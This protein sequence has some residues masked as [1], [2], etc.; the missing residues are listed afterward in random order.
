MSEDETPSSV[1]QTQPSGDPT[2]DAGRSMLTGDTAPA[3]PGAGKP[4]PDSFTGYTIVREIHRGGQGVVYEAVQKSTK[5]KV[6]LKVLLEGPYASKSAKRRFEREI[7]LV[8]QLKHPNII[9]IFHSG[10]TADGRPFYVMDYV[11]G[12]PLHHYVREKKLPLEDALKLFA[13]VC[14]GVQF[15]HQRGV[16][17][18]DLKPS[19]IVVDVDGNAKILDFGLA[20]WLAAPVDTAVTLTQKVVG[21]LPYMSPEQTRGNPDEIDTRTDVYALGVILYELLTGHYPYPVAGQMAD[22]L[23][24]IAK[25][26]PT[27]PSHAWSG[28]SGVT[29]RL[30]K[31]LRPGQC[32]IDDEVQT[33]VLR[34]L[35]KERDRRYQSAGELA[36]DVDHYL[37]NEPIEAKRDSGWYVLKKA[38]ARRRWQVI[39]AA[40]VM[41]LAVGSYGLWSHARSVAEA[42]RS[43]AER[44]AEMARMEY[45]AAVIESDWEPSSNEVR[46]LYDEFFEKLK[47]GATTPEER[48]LFLSNAIR[49]DIKTR[50]MCALDYPMSIA[51]TVEQGMDIRAHGI[52]PR[53]V[54][55][56][57][58]DGKQIGE[59]DEWDFDPESGQTHHVYTR[60]VNLATAFPELDPPRELELKVVA[61]LTFCWAVRDGQAI[62]SDEWEANVICREH[63]VM[64][65]TVLV[66]RSLPDN[67]PVAITSPDAAIR[68]Q[69]GFRIGGLLIVREDGC[70]QLYYRNTSPLHVAGRLE[71]VD[72]KTGAVLG[73]T[74]LHAA[75]ARANMGVSWIADWAI[76]LLRSVK[77]GDVETLQFRVIPDREVALSVPELETYW[78]LPLELTAPVGEQSPERNA[79]FQTYEQ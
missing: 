37:A 9:S 22:V 71:I 15:A 72:P 63:R 48:R 36:R 33:I 24:H 3:G 38:V 68:V 66:L 17:H 47:A 79:E 41:L 59:V 7:E 39:S 61:N 28:D 46:G 10:E 53:V 29:E 73:V 2:Q 56:F 1:D 49:A 58:L 44:Q 65:E 74:S 70:V 64:T 12:Q 50:R 19:N 78:G 23:K 18:R 4:P 16:I 55:R 31:R 32:P 6:A 11:R 57:S 14:D 45:V 13:T 5:R 62:P 54:A 67:Y 69:D 20:K 26:P 77:S 43:E 21:T 52:V 75:P 25:T 35:A 40:A 42:A 60:R 27:P 34:A 8:A 51:L 76:E 30:A